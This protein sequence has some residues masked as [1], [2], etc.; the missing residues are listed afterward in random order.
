MFASTT[1]PLPK[2]IP[3]NF[4]NTNKERVFYVFDHI[5]DYHVQPTSVQSV[6]LKLRFH[7]GHISIFE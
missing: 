5:E 6:E 2:D 4:L 3:I 1:V 7:D